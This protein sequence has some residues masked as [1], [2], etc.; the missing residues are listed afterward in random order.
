MSINQLPTKK[1]LSPIQIETCIIHIANSFLSQ[2]MNIKSYE[3]TIIKDDDSQNTI[4]LKKILIDIAKKSRLFSKKI[5]KNVDITVG[6]FE[7]LEK[8]INYELLHPKPLSGF[9]KQCRLNENGDLEANAVLLCM[10]LIKSHQLLQSKKIHLRYKLAD[11]VIASLYENKTK[12]YE[13]ARILA[14]RYVEELH[15]L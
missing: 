4:T 9:R 8:T 13:N 12:G 10:T 7:N 5:N 6:I 11:D 15:K 1:K 3:D 14:R 2:G